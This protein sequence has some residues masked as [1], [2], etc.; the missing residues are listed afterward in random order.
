M[1][2]IAQDLGRPCFM[3]DDWVSVQ[4]TAAI[5]KP[6]RDDW[7]MDIPDSALHALAIARQ[8]Q[9]AARLF[10]SSTR[11]MNGRLDPADV[12]AMWSSLETQLT[13]LKSDWCP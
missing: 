4:A 5:G 12:Y 3:T 9:Q 6:S 10:G 2:S 8:V 11:T 13:E 1:R 7:L